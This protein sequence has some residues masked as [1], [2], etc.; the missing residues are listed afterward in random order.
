MLMD[1]FTLDVS[2]IGGLSDEEFYKLATSN[3][4]LKMERTAQGEII[5]MALTG[6]NTGRKNTRLT[7]RLGLWALE[8]KQGE[9]FDSSTGFK[10]PSGAVRSPD[11]AFVRSERWK[12]L[13]TNERATF[14]PL[15]PDFVV[16]LMSNSDNLRPSQEKMRE[17]IQNGCQL[18]WLVDVAEQR[19]FV[20][21]AN[22]SQ[23][24]IEGFHSVISGEDVLPNFTF[25]LAELLDDEA[26]T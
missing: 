14:P 16:E 26:G 7:M 12:A 21:R 22:G 20:Y 18:A 6:G 2:A 23:T 24:S 3:K 1:M 11:A 17:W 10:L 15:C 25:D 5:I 13:S 19:V 4:E 8:S 9:V